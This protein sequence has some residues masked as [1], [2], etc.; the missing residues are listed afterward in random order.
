MKYI[1]QVLVY[2]AVGLSA[3]VFSTWLFVRFE[4]E[5]LALEPPAGHRG[6]NALELESLPVALGDS[7]HQTPEE[8]LAAAQEEGGPEGQPVVDQ[9]GLSRLPASL[10]QE[11]EGA[12]AVLPDKE[13]GIP[14]P[15]HAG[16]RVPPSEGGVTPSSSPQSLLVQALE[17]SGGEAEGGD[18]SDDITSSGIKN[19][20]QDKVS[21]IEKILSEYNYD[22]VRRRNPFK[23]PF[24]PKPRPRPQAPQPRV[25]ER[26]KP[27]VVQQEEKEVEE[28]VYIPTPAEQ[29]ELQSMELVGITWGRSIGPSKAFFKDPNGKIHELQKNDR[30]G[31]NRGIVYQLREDE[32]VILEENSDGK[33]GTLYEPVI[34]G[35]PRQKPSPS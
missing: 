25:I 10:D 21:N 20:I 6:E 3:L 23:P 35:L 1:F 18:S 15:P 22:P 4:F 14:P 8:M 7:G 28:E 24:K 26:V 30:I 13:E 27:M 5:A 9:E 2:L 16:D 31:M 29:F 32:V 11:G 19:R 34:V 17:G 33:G 12:L